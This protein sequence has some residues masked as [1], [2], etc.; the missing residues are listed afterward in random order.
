MQLADEYHILLNSAVQL[1]ELNK[2]SHSFFEKESLR[3]ELRQIELRLQQVE[4]LLLLQAI[5]Q[6]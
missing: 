6:N 3:T 4:S 1:I 5:Q 2:S